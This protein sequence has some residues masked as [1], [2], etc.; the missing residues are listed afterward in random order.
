MVKIEI[1]KGDFVWIGVLIVFVGMGF[2]YGYN[3]GS[4]PAVMGHS[5]QELEVDWG[6]I[7]GVPAGFSD[8]VD[9][10]GGGALSCTTVTCSTAWSCSATCSSG[11]IMTGG[12][13]NPNTNG[14]LI[15]SLPSGNGW[16]C[17]LHRGGTCYAR[18][19]MIS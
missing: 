3:S 13:G 9:D 16:Q 4:T 12:G 10:A 7:A 8:G 5:G 2:V 1:G 17:G 18:C 11:Y 19:C 15:L 6:D 14:D